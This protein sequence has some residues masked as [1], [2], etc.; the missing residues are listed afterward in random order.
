MPGRQ[1]HVDII[2]YIDHLILLYGIFFK[3][4]MGGAMF[5]FIV[6]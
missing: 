4:D 1:Q 3:F 6:Y 5:L 2:I